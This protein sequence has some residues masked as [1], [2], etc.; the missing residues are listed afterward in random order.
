M[1]ESRRLGRRSSIIGAAGVVVL[2]GAG[3]VA[4][5][6]LL[7]LQRAVF[8][9]G[10]PPTDP[11]AF[12]R[13]GADLALASAA[14][15]RY[16]PLVLATVVVYGALLVL[17][18]QL[19]GRLVGWTAVAAGTLVQIVLVPVK[20]GLSI[21][22]YSYVAHGYLALQPGDSPYRT[23]A[24]AV[25]GT[26]LGQTLFGEG[27]MAVHPESP[28]GPIW[29]DVERL[30]VQLAGADVDLAVVLLKCVVVAASIGIGF[31]AS[32]LAARLRPGLGP[33]AAAAWLLNPAV[34]QEF[35]SDGHNDAVAIFFVAL[36]LL[37]AVRGW[38]LVAVPAIALGTLVKYTPAL[39]ALPVLVILLRQATSKRRVLLLGAVATVVSLGVAWLAWLPWWVDPDSTL[40]GLRASTT[41][42][43]AP[44]PMG[45]LSSLWNDP[46]V[47]TRSPLPT[48]ASL[49]VFA[50]VVLA[51]SWGRKTT[52][53]LAG[54]AVIALTVLAMSP[55]Y[56]PWYSTLAI[57]VLVLRPTWLSLA[58]VVLLTAGSRL[59]GI[60]QDLAAIGGME[61]ADASF[62]GTLS[63]LTLPVAAC[64]LLAVVAAV[65]RKLLSRRRLLER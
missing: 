20:P 64:A 24:A 54:C 6:P 26:P 57:A 22:L 17:V 10:L 7:A 14:P 8:T 36:A 59:A 34:V 1:E 38:V 60:W 28:Y 62:I 65:V 53:W 61:Y 11:F 37:A 50:V 56:W 46:Y 2:V 25:A 3:A 45:F 32:A 35:A 23:A 43:D 27:W 18:R 19:P 13:P 44:S 55:T 39:F 42:Y 31:V 63:G 4:Y 58:Q 12:P 52:T 9:S 47:R 21:D 40:A 48:Y 41:A 29:T 51:C 30:C 16:V 33:L 5:I 49:V 15:E